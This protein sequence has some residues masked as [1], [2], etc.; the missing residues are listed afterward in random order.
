MLGN[1]VLC[2]GG[3]RAGDGV[4]GGGTSERPGHGGLSLPLSV[5]SGSRQSVCAEM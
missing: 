5:N 4:W 2:C 1:S 3:R